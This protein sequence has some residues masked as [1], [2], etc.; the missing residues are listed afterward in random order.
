MRVFNGRGAEFDAVVDTV[1]RSGVQVVLG[2]A[3]QPAPEPRVA[4]TVAQ[5]VLKGDKM[6]EVVRDAVMI[7]AAALLPLVTARTEISLAALERSRRR[8][9]WERI[10]VSSAKQCGRAVVPAIAE[11]AP[12]DP[13]ALRAHDPAAAVFALVEPHTESG[14]PVSSLDAA[15]IGARATLVIGPEGGW[16]GEEIAAL[17]KSSTLVTLGGRTLRADAMAVVALAAL[18]ARCGEY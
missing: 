3:C 1:D 15:R 11:P 10:A 7:G 16:S 18:Y 14:M 4:V 12:F 13:K 5:A 9:R 2:D 6:D 8:E 17:S